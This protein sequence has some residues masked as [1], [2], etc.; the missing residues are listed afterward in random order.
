MK[1]CLL[2]INPCSGQLK[3][4]SELVDVIKILNE[5]D[6]KVQVQITLNHNHA[7]EIGANAPDVDLIICSGGDGTVNQVVSGMIEGN[8]KIPLGYIPSGSTNDF[9]NTLGLSFNIKEATKNIVSGKEYLIDIGNFNNISN[10]V[11]VASFGAFTSVSY[12]T[13][14]AAKNI[15]GNL[16]YIVNGIADLAN[17]RPYKVK[18]KTKDI[19]F[20]GEYLLG[21]VLNTTSVGGILKINTLDVDLSDGLF[22]VV[23]IKVPKDIIDANKI[24]NGLMT[25]NFS[26]SS[27][28]TFLK[29]DDITLYLDK[30]TSWSLDGEEVKAG[31][32]VHITNINQRIGIVK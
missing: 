4:H 21:L 20:E 19:E 18:G 12:N 15:F 31:K 29:T 13:P 26:D 8:K 32:K 11:Y 2:I 9:A 24:G 6:Y 25:C 5:N 23:L 28:F 30:E 16:A 3:I 27:V 10:F 1:K 17:V 7:K 14:Q 22:E